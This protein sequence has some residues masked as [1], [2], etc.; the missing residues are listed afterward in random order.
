MLA[1]NLSFAIA[2]PG[3]NAEQAFAIRADA[4]GNVY[5]LATDAVYKFAPDGTEIWSSPYTASSGINQKESL[6]VDNSGD[7][8]IAGN[9]SNGAGS[10]AKFGSTALVSAGGNDGYLAKLDSNGNFVWAESFGGSDDD[11]AYGVAADSSG[12]AYITGHFNG[13]ATIGTGQNAKT[14]TTKTGDILVAKFDP[15]GA[16]LWVNAYGDTGT[17]KGSGDGRGIAVDAQGNA[18]VTGEFSSPFSQV[19]FDPAAPGTHDLTTFFSTDFLLKLDTNGNYVWAKK[20]NANTTAG[21]GSAEGYGIAVDAQGNIYNTGTFGGPVELDPNGGDLNTSADFVFH[22]A[23]VLKL[24]SS[25]N[26]DWAADLHN[27]GIGIGGLQPEDIATDASGNVYT[28]GYYDG[29]ANFDPNGSQLRTSAGGDDVYVSALTSQGSFLW[30]ATAGENGTDQ[31]YG[32]A[33]ASAAGGAY[34]YA[35]GSYSNTINFNP[36]NGPADNVPAN[37]IWD[38]FLWGL[39][40]FHNQIGGV[41]W[42]DQ[43]GDNIRE[44]TEAGV[45]G[46]PVALFTGT[47]GSGTQVA[48]TVTDS[49]GLY[50]F[51]G[52]SVNQSYYV[53]VSLPPGDTF[54]TEN[55]GTDPTIASNVSPL[56]GDSGAITVS[57]GQSVIVNAGF[58]QVVT[59]NFG[60]AFGIPSIGFTYG[61]SIVADS[62]GDI[63]VAGNFDGTTTFGSGAGGVTLSTTY[64]PNDFI[65]KY[66]PDGSLLWVQQMVSDLWQYA[67]TL[68]L[69][70][71]GNLYLSGVLTGN[72]TI[73]PLA[74][75]DAKNANMAYLAKFD[76][77]GNPLW[78]TTVI[79]GAE[80]F[81]SGLAVDPL[82]DAYV[83]GGFTGSATVN[84]PTSTTLTSAGGSDVFVVKYSPGGN[85]QWAV[86]YGG[87]SDDMAD[88]AAVDPAG[89]P[90]ITGIFEATATFGSTKLTSAA[91]SSPNDFVAKLSSSSG[92]VVWAKALTSKFASGQIIFDVVQPLNRIAVDAQ[93]NVYTTGYFGLDAQ[94][95]PNN[96]TDA[97]TGINSQFISKLDGNGNFVWGKAVGGG[98]AYDVEGQG[99]AVDSSGNVYTTGSYSGTANFNPNGSPTDN[100]TSGSALYNVFISELD[101]KGNLVSAES[102][103]GAGEDQ[104]NAI[105]VDT[106]GNVYVTGVLG[107]GPTKF[108]PFTVGAASEQDLLVLRLGNT[109]GALVNA[110]PSFTIQGPQQSLPLNAPAQTVPGFLSNIVPGPPGENNEV[111]TFQITNDNPSLFSVE[112]SIDATGTLTYTPTPG[113][114]G[115]ADITVVAHNNGGTANGGSDTSAPQTFVISVGVNHAPTFTPGRDQAVL[116]NSGAHGPVQWATN[117]SPGPPDEAGQTLNFI[118]TY[119]INS[120]NGSSNVPAGS[121]A[122]FSVAPAIDST[123]KLTY[124]LAPNVWG[125]AVVN[126]ELHD[127]GGTAFG[128]NDTSSPQVFNINALFVNQPPSF[129]AGSD[130]TTNENSGPRSVA[131]WATQ[132]LA[133]PPSEAGEQ[134]T[135]IVNTDNDSLFSSLPAIDPTTGTLTYTPALDVS[136][137]ANVT[138]ELRDNGGTANGGND[139]SPQQTFSITVNFVNQPPTFTAGPDVAVDENSGAQAVTGWAK[140]I[141]PGSLQQQQAG[142]TVNFTITTDNANLFSVPPAIDPTT[143][144]LTYTPAP[145]EFGVANV[146]VELHNSGGTA[147]GGNDTSLPQTFTITVNFVNHVPSFT[148]GGNQA[149]LENAGTQV[150]AGWASN[151]SAGPPSEASQTLN[152]VV[153]TDNSALFPTLPSID[154]VTGKLTYTPAADED[155]VA[156][157]SVKLHD[158]GGTANGGTD[159]SAVQTFTISVTFVNQPPSFTAG[160]NQ[161]V[162]ETPGPQTVA[163]WASNISVGPPNQV[164]RSQ[165]VNFIVTT[166][167]DSL[168]SALPSIDPATGNLN[169]T[170]AVY[171]TGI[172]DVTVRLQNSGGTANGGVDTSAPQTFTITVTAS[173]QPPSFTPGSDETLSGSFG[174]VA[175]PNWATNI[176]NGPP[177][178]AGQLLNFIISTDNAGLFLVPPAIDSSSGDLTFTPIPGMS[179]QANVTAAL[180]NSGGT[181]NGGIDTSAPATFLIS[182]TFVNQAPSF[183]IPSSPPPAVDENAGSQRVS[184]WATSINAGPPDESYQKVN[185]TV[186]TDNNALFSV[187]PAIDPATG[188][189]TYTPAPDANGV[190]NVSVA[191]HDN[192]G[193]AN[194]GN[195][196]SRLQKFAITV[197]PVNQAPFFSGGPSVQVSENSGRQTFSGWASGM[198][199][200]APN[201]ASQ[202]LNFV[203]TTDNASLFA[204]APQ[205]DPTK[206]DLTFTPATNVD[207]TATVNVALHD[208]GGTQNG[209]HDTSAAQ[210]F[211]IAVAFVNQPP[212]FIGGQSA[213][214]KEENAVIA[215]SATPPT[216]AV[217]VNWMPLSGATGYDIYRGTSSGQ[218]NMLVGTV[219]GTA[220]SF[221]DTGGGIVALPPTTNPTGLPAPVQTSLVAS[222]SGGTLASGTYYY[223]VTALGNPPPVDESTA[224]VQ[225]TV[226]AWATNINP[227]APNQIDETLNFTVVNDNPSLFS[228]PPQIDPVTGDLTY[229]PAPNASGVAH[230]VA[231]LHNSGGTTNGGRDS[232]GKN[233]FTITVNFVNQPPSFVTA[234]PNPPAANENSGAQTV[235]GFA[236]QISPSSTYPPAANQANE[237]VQFTVKPVTNG[238]LFTQ[239]GQ[240]AIDASGNLTYTL[241]PN[242]FGTSTVTVTAENNGGAANGGVDAS[243]PQTFTITANFVPQPPSFTSLTPKAVWNEDSGKA[244]FSGFAAASPGID[245]DQ[246]N[247]TISYLATSV[248]TTGQPLFASTGQPSIHA[249]GTLTFTPGT[250]V[251]GT[252]TVTVVAQETGGALGANVVSSHPVTFQIEIDQVDH[253]PTKA[254]G[255]PDVSVNENAADF[256]FSNAAVSKVFDD[257][258][259]DLHLGDQLRLSAA[260]DTPNLV[261]ASL[262]GSDPSTATLTLHFLPD[263]YGTATI[264]LKATDNAGASADDKISVTVYQSNEPPS[265]TPGGNLQVVMNAGPQSAPWAGKIVDGKDDP[266]TDTLNFATSILSATNPNLFSSPPT[267]DSKTGILSFTPAANQFGTATIAVALYNSGGTLHGGSDTSP[268]QTFQIEVA[269]QPTAVNHSYLLRTGAAA[270]VAAGSGMLVGDHDPSGLPLSARLVSPPSSGSVRLN[271]DGSFT[272]TPSA[273]FQGSDSFTY[274]VTNGVAVSN[275]ATVTITSEQAAIVDKLYQQVLGR[276]PDAGG[277]AYWTQQVGAGQPYGTVA[278]GIFESDERLDPII[279]GYYQQFLLRPA[280]TA[281]LAYWD[282]VWKDSGGPEQVISGMISSPEF[283]AS[284]AAAR[285]DLSSNAAWVTALYQ[286]LLNREPD[287]GGLQYWTN[288]LSSG[289]MTL[290][291]VVNG[292]EYGTE[293]FQNLTTHFFQQYLGRNPTAAELAGYVQQFEQGA[294]DADIQIELINLPEYRNSPP[295]PA[296]G[297]LELLS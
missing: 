202:A 8:Y 102:Y 87:A 155:G 79:S 165:S 63:Y 220:T 265:F 144:T 259:V 206:G 229:T 177:N 249:D 15:T 227:G 137:V 228:T 29:I 198:N 98:K 57:P 160:P 61:S 162:H 196:T 153:T 49:L 275:V 171:A 180:H 293:N 7:I 66:A 269:G 19:D 239:T 64:A 157:V 45:G 143:G 89:N 256:V 181:A 133:G 173:N 215:S 38:G 258:D 296:T 243:Q 261:T 167:N 27:T 74:L 287:S 52:V 93:G 244:S 104:G 251:F 53:Q 295:P 216:G 67:P 148:E 213:V 164:A 121:T 99:I 235:V 284:A 182:V 276:A 43:N 200:G 9:F 274:Q 122:L 13:T 113:A 36:G 47:P 68:K 207:G 281:G 222:A 117:L 146:T 72:T 17:G 142:Q 134:L 71:F 35:C 46:V 34:V 37:A 85:A 40:Y 231:Q 30:V 42:N 105:A 96:S 163:G 178:Q 273:S 5:E 131:N 174:Q 188:D 168:F 108:G 242:V 252:A 292:F 6:A 294:T 272:Y 184:G 267:V 3:P 297:T 129:V 191:L 136:G 183:T 285:P 125:T 149:V 219:G 277:L 100:L 120:L 262:S 195:D 81:N 138:V 280:D 238:A 59:N 18:Y 236:T 150:I 95:D 14:L 118:V 208:D 114:G 77:N 245:G 55:V 103:G 90:V 28:V 86:N 44:S 11:V 248:A 62:L 76:S 221:V 111:L 107:S 135:F 78:A 97:V 189:L 1:A 84:T 147:N 91:G 214:S 116:E 237:S 268:V 123:G 56:T 192:G 278:Q 169:Y 223:E 224:S 218:E 170:P 205:I 94:L 33:T 166:D 263:Q 109:F 283:Y 282:Q 232:S 124:T 119:T 141:S 233:A 132:I 209:G 126:V 234:N 152:F 154:P 257:V 290:V 250:H 176:S 83:V 217:T 288:N 255:L 4:A 186:T 130:Q 201:E 279:E 82:G 140:N 73:G 211:T 158:N 70:G 210:S 20:L 26:F 271:A 58:E 286:R 128:G 291:D 25:G 246:Q 69:D 2:G 264:D 199:A 41:V 115:T 270:S 112:P 225:Q 254:Q 185:F 190:A 80:D 226:K 23:F 241:N 65:A 179:G 266:A 54:A 88:S 151:I 60:L 21:D 193:T 22:D 24:D 197:N 32:V 253:P 161:S 156:H 172:A 110:A 289:Q 194:G 10:P 212:S 48:T 203:V 145:D 240:P 75:S 204:V 127:N 175:V 187:L 101:K 230:V 50:S 247:E 12:N 92:S 106:F 39:N 51:N 16:L 260:S 139:L 31:G 159:T